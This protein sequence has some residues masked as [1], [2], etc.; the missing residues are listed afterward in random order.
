MTRRILRK[1]RDA[2]LRNGRPTRQEKLDQKCKWSLHC[3]ECTNDRCTQ[4]TEPSETQR[5][6]QEYDEARDF[7]D[8]EENEG[9]GN[10]GNFGA[11]LY[12]EGTENCGFCEYTKSCF[13]LYQAWL[14]TWTVYKGDKEE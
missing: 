13:G 12:Q 1:V 14:R 8:W 7:E 6:T 10:C 4:R 11:E 3:D 9:V 5:R 2:K